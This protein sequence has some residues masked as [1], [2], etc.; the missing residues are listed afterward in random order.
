[1]EIIYEGI[2]ALPLELREPVH[3]ALNAEPL[4]L[5]DHRLTVS[6]YRDT[7]GW[8]KI[9]LVPTGMVETGWQL[10]EGLES[11]I[12]EVLAER[13]SRLEW[14][15]YRLGGERIQ[16][17]AE[18]VPVTFVNLNRVIPP[19]AGGYRFP[20]SEGESWWATQGWHHG[21]A[22]DFQPLPGASEAVLAAESGWLTEL[23]S[24]GYQSLL[25][26]AHADGRFTYYL[27]V[28][29]GMQVRRTLLDQAVE[30]G[31]FLGFLMQDEN[32]RTPC[33]QG[34]ARHLHF[35]INTRA[36]LMEG[37]NLEDIAW[38]ATC[39]NAPPSYVSHNRPSDA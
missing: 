34:G 13:V 37:Y 14:Q 10:A 12:V 6:A 31:Q 28:T 18:R 11:L 15:A 4:G 19:L 38:T 21:N 23:C 30:R 20:W 22:L 39:C 5:P 26:I 9:T 25:Q 27:H 8:A 36:T 1:L 35:A 17:V 3:A 2:Y 24:D 7:D 16:S 29:V 32:F 33:G